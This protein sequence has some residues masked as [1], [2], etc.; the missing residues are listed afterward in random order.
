MCAIENTRTEKNNSWVRNRFNEWRIA[1]YPYPNFL[2]GGNQLLARPNIQA[3][4]PNIQTPIMNEHHVFPFSGPQMSS[5]NS[6]GNLV[7]P[8]IMNTALMP[9]IVPIFGS[10]VYNYQKFDISRFLANQ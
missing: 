3:I 9:H 4:F 1:S 8:G 5:S 10:T 6:T 7:L 2:V